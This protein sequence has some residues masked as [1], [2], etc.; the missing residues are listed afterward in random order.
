[1]ISLQT[2]I[3]LKKA[4]LIWHPSL[5]DFFAIPERD[6]D[7]QIFVISEVQVTV[8]VRKGAEELSFQ[9]ASE[10]ALDSLVTSESVWLPT[11]SQ[12]REE[13]ETL[14]LI[15][16]EPEVRL[17]C[18]IDG[19]EC[20]ISIDGK[21]VGFKAG[22]ACEAYASALLFLLLENRIEDARFS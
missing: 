9:G 19:Y 11:E 21:R 13:L 17:R 2:A 3:K 6:L 8:E 12:L 15:R 10:W 5:H 18:N 14:L 4:G 7:D 1:M 20:V 16:R 22:D